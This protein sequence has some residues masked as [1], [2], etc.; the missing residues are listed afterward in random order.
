MQENYIVFLEILKNILYFIFNAI[1]L[2]V[3]LKKFY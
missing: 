3:E 2:F 1:F